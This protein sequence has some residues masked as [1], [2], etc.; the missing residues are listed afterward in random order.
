MV[1]SYLLSSIREAE[2]LSNKG[3]RQAL[4]SAGVYEVDKWD[5]FSLV[6][7]WLEKFG[8]KELVG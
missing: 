8:V 3:L 7:T 6:A 1:V 5:R 2:S 4:K